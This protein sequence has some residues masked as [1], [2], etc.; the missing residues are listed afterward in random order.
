MHAADD[1][2]AQPGAELEPVIAPGDMLICTGTM[3]KAGRAM[4]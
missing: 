4:H 1:G 3:F 2:F